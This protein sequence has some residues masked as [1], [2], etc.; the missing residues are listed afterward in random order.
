VALICNASSGARHGSNTE[1]TLPVGPRDQRE[2]SASGIR[3]T[4]PSVGGDRRDGV[5]I[6]GRSGGARADGHGRR[7]PV[8]GLVA[9]AVPLAD[10]VQGQLA[11]CEGGG[12]PASE[13]T[14]TLTSSGRIPA[15]GLMGLLTLLAAALA[16]GI[17]ALPGD[18]SRGQARGDG[19]K[20]GYAVVCRSCG[21]LLGANTHRPQS[22]Y[23]NCA[24]GMTTRGNWKS[25]TVLLRGRPCSSCG[26]HLFYRDGPIRRLICDGRGRH[27]PRPLLSPIDLRG[28]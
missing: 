9:S 13:R 16:R 23:R 10:L 25:N 18:S 21:A 27:E 4:P 19:G 7:G 22:I 1:A 5:V 11:P 28:R 6:L 2:R 26:L 12:L 14:L 17:I 24:C 15:E 8:R 3:D 20:L